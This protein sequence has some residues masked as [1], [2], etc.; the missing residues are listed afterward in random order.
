MQES[1]S[2]HQLPQRDQAGLLL[3]HKEWSESVADGLAKSVGISE[4]SED[5]WTVIWD[6]QD[7]FHTYGVAPAMKNICHKHKHKDT[8]VH[9]LF[10]TCLNAW[11]V[12]GLPD[13]G[14]EAKTYLSDSW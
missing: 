8:W 10:G 4:L 3:S 1:H 7:Y 9:D 12:A 2:S 14:E 6:L 13:P 5:H 11:I